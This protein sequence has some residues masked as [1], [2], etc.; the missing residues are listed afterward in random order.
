MWINCAK[1]PHEISLLATDIS[2]TRR[3]RYQQW[4]AF[5]AP[6]GSSHGLCF[7]LRCP[8]RRGPQPPAV[9][10]GSHGRRLRAGPARPGQPLPRL[11]HRAGEAMRR[12]GSDESLPSR[13]QAQARACM[14]AR[15]PVETSPALIPNAPVK[16]K[17]RWHVHQ[18]PCRV[19]IS[20]ALQQAP[21]KKSWPTGRST[22]DRWWRVCHSRV[23]SGGLV[24]A[25][26]D[27]ALFAWCNNFY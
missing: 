21:V 12:V 3:A 1:A 2:R 8:P 13:P 18:P 11:L 24:G 20:K 4:S 6:T 10:V 16:L 25:M 27:L 22:G 19:L 26:A 14:H 23:V 5:R 7:S 15:R 9:P 17:P